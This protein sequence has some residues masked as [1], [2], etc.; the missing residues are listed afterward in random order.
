MTELVM[1]EFDQECLTPGEDLVQNAV[2]CNGKKKKE[3]FWQLDS[4]Q[5]SL[6]PLFF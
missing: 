5:V 1:S 6:H 3:N 2:R 4:K